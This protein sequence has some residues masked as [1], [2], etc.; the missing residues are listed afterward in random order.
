MIEKPA[1]KS[2]RADR[3]NNNVGDITI[4][5]LHGFINNSNCCWMNATIQCIMNIKVFRD[6]IRSG[7]SN[8]LRKLV[9]QYDNPLL[10]TLD[11]S[12][13]RDLFSADFSLGDQHDSQEFLSRL[14]QSFPVLANLCSI[15]LLDITICDCGRRSRTQYSDMYTLYIP[16]NR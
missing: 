7:A 2:A 8:C 14:L 3:R 4:Q 1:E 13:M 9:Q 11:L 5:R 16:N 6:A 12:D 10:G 15:D